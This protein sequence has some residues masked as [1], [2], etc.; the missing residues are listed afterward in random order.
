MFYKNARIFCSDFTF[1]KGA[2]EVVDGKFGAILLENV[3]EDVDVKIHSQSCK[4]WLRGPAEVLDKLTEENVRVIVDYAAQDILM[5]TYNLLQVRFE[6]VDENGA[7]I[8][9]VGAV[10]PEEEDYS[11]TVNAMVTLREE[12]TGE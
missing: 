4:V 9:D 12:E 10:S 2:F 11:Y 5:N 8:A 7:V 1:R 3:P 6:I